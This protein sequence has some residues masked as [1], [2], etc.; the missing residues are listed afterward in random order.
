MP[1]NQAEDRY[2]PPSSTDIDFDQLKFRDV[3]EEELYWPN[4]TLNW[5]SNTA[6]RKIDENTGMNT[7]TR[8]VVSV[9]LDT[10]V[11]QKI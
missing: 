2:N 9:P 6:H 1:N 3:P 11:Y 10:I 5:K 4:N 8:E 7:K